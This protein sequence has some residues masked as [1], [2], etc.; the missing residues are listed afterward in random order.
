MKAGFIGAGK[1]GFSL[2]KYLTENGVVVTGYYS[3]S[4][5]SAMEAA[6]FTGTG[7][8]R[9][10]I[11]IIRDS[12]TLFITVPDGAITQVWEYIRNLPI[13]NKNI[14][15]C[16]GSISSTAFFDAEEK[17]AFRYSVHPLYAFSNKYSS[18]EGLKGAFFSIEGSEAHLDEMTEV[19]S[20]PG[21]TV[22]PISSEKKSL[23]H[24]AAVMV[25]NHMIAL[26]DA[27]AEMLS[28]CGFDRGSAIQALAPL[29]RGNVDAVIDSGIAAALTGPVERNDTGTVAAHLD[30]LGKGVETGE[31]MA[32]LYRSL[33]SR[34]VR[35]AE[36]KHPDRD[37]AALAALLSKEL[38]YQ[39]GV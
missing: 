15:H 9:D 32:D 37:Y 12:D 21:N 30:A 18:Y 8:Y 27:A 24:C 6:R 38:K 34:L 22:I 7:Y 25:S 31:D 19:F 36:E 26:A 23:Y 14:C 17:G 33:A 28:S 13:K 16:S 20:Q 3:R 10:L 1:V 35:I 29:M 39:K 5:A 11:D 4:A 2:G